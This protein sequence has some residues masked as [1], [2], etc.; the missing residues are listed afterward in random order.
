[1]SLSNASSS[2]QPPT[3]IAVD[4]V[5]DRLRRRVEALKAIVKLHD[6]DVDGVDLHRTKATSTRSKYSLASGRK[7]TGRKRSG[8]A[9]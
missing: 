2:A 9:K 5:N 6:L 3:T 7:S 8:A 1:M 4:E